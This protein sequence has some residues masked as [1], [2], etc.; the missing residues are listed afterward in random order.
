MALTPS[1]RIT[2]IKEISSRLA[3]EDW[4]LIDVTLENFGMPTSNTWSSG[5]DSYL[6]EMVKNAP[7][8]ALVDLAMHAGFH[9]EVVTKPTFEPPFWHKGYLKVFISH[10]SSHKGYASELQEALLRFGIS[11][12]VAHSD[13][14]PTTEWQVQI[15]AALSTADSLVA[16]LQPEFHKSNW[17]DQ[18]IG[19]SMGR[20]IPVFAVRLGQDPYG[21]IGR[22]QAFA[23]M[24]KHV[25]GVAEELFDAYRKSKQT[26]RKMGEI[27]VRLFEDSGSFADAKWHIGW[28]EEL[29][30][31]DTNFSKRVKAAAESNSQ[32]YNS[33]GVSDRVNVLLKKWSK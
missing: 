29:T 2:L 18:E 10:L 5:R 25:K 22:F 3:G 27:I 31:W 21:F 28:L 4:N 23:G 7:E 26:Q 11:G 33:W 6:V 15:E 9:L 24:G 14:E 19:F 12:F 1:Q 16:L 13:I 20:G 8:E 30:E 17:T 32:I